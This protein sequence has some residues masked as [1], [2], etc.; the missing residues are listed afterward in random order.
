MA[1][2]GTQTTRSFADLDINAAAPGT[3]TAGRP[4][5]ARHGRTVETWAWNGYLSANYHALQAALNRRAGDGLLLKGSYTYSKAIN[6]TD[7]DGW[8]GVMFNHESAFKRNRAQAGYDI[9]H[10]LQLGFVYELPFGKGK[11]HANSGAS[12]WVLGGW[13]FNG[14]FAAYQGRPFTVTASGAGLNAPGS[15]QTADQVKPTV[16]KLG[17]VGPGQFYYD[18]TAFAPV[19]EA[20][21]G[22]SGRNL[23]RGPGV[24]NLDVGVFPQ[25]PD[26]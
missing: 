4:L 22:T 6:W 11:K 18:R 24:V 16:E 10:M 7:E 9:P 26:Y 15:A 5:F 8:T 20:R 25:V 12:S 21:F 3:G 23:L 1:Y 14:V 2:V 17:G 19:N 13:Q